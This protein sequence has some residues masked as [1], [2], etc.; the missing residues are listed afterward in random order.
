M[1]P[2]ISDF[3][4]LIF[5]GFVLLLADRYF[6]IE[7]FSNPNNCGVGMPP[8]TNGTRCING[9]CKSDIPPLLGPNTLPVFP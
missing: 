5:I 2:S 9:C 8:C 6:R 1:R 4:T 3:I 7:G